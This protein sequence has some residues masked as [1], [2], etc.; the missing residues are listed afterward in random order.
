MTQAVVGKPGAKK[1]IDVPWFTFHT[2]HDDGTPT[3]FPERGWPRIVAFAEKMLLVPKGVGAKTPFI[4]R[5]WQ[6]DILKQMYPTPSELEARGEDTHRPRQGLISLPRGNGKTGLAAVLALYAL[7]MDEVEAPQ[8]L[9]VASDERQAGHVYRAA[10]RMIE[11]SPQLAA[12]THFYSDRIV[13]PQVDGEMRALPADVGAL[14]GWDPTLMIVD[15][16]HVVTEEV[17]EAVTSASGKREESL[18]LAI[19]TPSDTVESVMW[20][21]V[22]WGREEDH[23]PDEFVFIEYNAPADCALDDEDAWKEANPALD[24]F[25]QRDALRS[26]LRTIRE[27]AF[28][29]Y[30]LGQWVGGDNAWLEFGMFEK[31]AQSKPVDGRQK[32]VLAFDGSA[33]GDATALMGCTVEAAPHLFRIGIWENPNDERWRVPRAEV[34]AAIDEAFERYN[35]VE[36]AFDPWGWR[37]EFETVA[38]K[39]GKRKV[40]EWNTAWK[41]RMAPATD[42]AYA[43]I[44]E[45][46]MTHE[47]D[48]R[49]TAHF[50]NCVATSSALGDIVHKDK[51]SSPRK[52]DAAVAG[53][54]ALD[55]AGHHFARPAGSRT[56]SW[57]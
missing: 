38:K 34:L 44:S 17:W 5:P 53:I 57:T 26:Q 16:M 20:K 43:L 55:R 10:K 22:Q 25:L 49:V 27:P 24:D 13:V 47:P 14:Q 48:E 21:L 28:R 33:S 15:E 39:H 2:H 12:R 31:T 8:V 30:R 35:V 6:V 23:D 9:V 11:T 19:S 50:Q 32:V 52:I 18:T 51:K 29:R 42:R 36:L 40:I 45:Q 7:Y 46:R 41:Q 1:A 54:V 56:G 4:L 37:T 3:G